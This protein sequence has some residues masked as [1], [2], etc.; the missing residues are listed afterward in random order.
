MKTH[1]T[2]FALGVAF[3]MILGGGALLSAN[4]YSIQVVTDYYAA[5]PVQHSN[6]G[7]KANKG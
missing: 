5:D 1:I 3:T 7:A 6:W 4:L 2:S